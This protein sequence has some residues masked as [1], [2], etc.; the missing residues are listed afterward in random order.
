MRFETKNQNMSNEFSERLYS[1]TEKFRNLVSQRRKETES[2]VVAVK[3]QI[4]ALS[5]EFDDRLEPQISVIIDKLTD[6]VSCNQSQVE[7][8]VSNLGDKLNK[9]D[10]EVRRVRD[11][12]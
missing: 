4:R 5:T 7:T 12:R 6:K 8:D 2:V 3:R 1:E 10:D 11:G 9:L